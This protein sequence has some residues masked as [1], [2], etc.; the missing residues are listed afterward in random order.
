M[1]QEISF[2]YSEIPHLPSPSVPG[3]LGRLIVGRWGGKRVLVFQG[4]LHY[5]EGYSLFEVTFPVRV[6]A[7]L[8][9]R[10]VFLASAAGGLRSD[11]QAGDL[12]LVRDHLNF[13]GEN[14]L[15]GLRDQHL[16]P[17]FVD[18]KDAYSPQ[19]RRLALEVAKEKGIVLRE[20]VYAAL[21]GPSYETPAEVRFLRAAGADAV[22]MSTVPE[23][24][25]ARQLGL[26]VL[27][28]C[29]L[30]NLLVDE[31]G[32]DHEEVV[33]QAARASE[34]LAQL[35]GGVLERLPA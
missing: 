15:R 29:C 23:V 17:L 2:D 25:V 24:I 33:R 26:T 30:T 21:P 6:L 35:F 12:M 10:T 32:V 3:H 4:R 22:G 34:R 5:Y 8:G 20:G 16:G 14:P 28:V 9:A 13:L 7:G 11:W 1:E 27:A 18:L 31:R 19:L